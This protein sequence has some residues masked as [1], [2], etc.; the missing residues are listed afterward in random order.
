MIYLALALPNVRGYGG[1]GLHG[2]HQPHHSSQQ[3]H[4]Q[5][6][7][8]SH[9]TKNVGIV[10]TNGWKAMYSDQ[11]Q[12]A[13]SVAGPLRL[14]RRINVQIGGNG[15]GGPPPRLRPQDGI[16]V[17]PRAFQVDH[18][19]STPQ[20]NAIMDRAM[21]KVKSMVKELEQEKGEAT[22]FLFEVHKKTSCRRRPS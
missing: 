11:P 20:L 7:S 16:A 21:E 12:P 9:N 4:E 6:R 3:H 17:E 14:P 10:N 8:R 2:G 5:L 13:S 22:T 18:L 15:F 19:P 1:Y